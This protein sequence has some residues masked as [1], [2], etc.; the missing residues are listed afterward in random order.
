MYTSLGFFFVVAIVAGFSSI[1][2][3]LAI[4]KF[5]RF[6]KL[7][8]GFRLTLPQVTLFLG[9]VENLIRL[10]VVI[11]PFGYRQVFP[12]RLWLTLASLSIAFSLTPSLLLLVYWREL[13]DPNT[14]KTSLFVNNGVG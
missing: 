3:I 8:N 14:I 13:V 2:V 5:S 1:C 10:A 9:V 6:Y 11:D 12:R 7:Q 4:H